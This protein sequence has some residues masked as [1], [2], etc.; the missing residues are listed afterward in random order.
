MGANDNNLG[1]L[2][3]A[4]TGSVFDPRQVVMNLRLRF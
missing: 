2:S 4:S 3:L 1:T